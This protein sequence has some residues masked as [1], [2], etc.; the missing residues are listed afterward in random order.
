MKHNDVTDKI[1]KSY[2]FDSSEFNS[3]MK[4]IWQEKVKKGLPVSIDIPND[5]DKEDLKLLSAFRDWL[6]DGQP[7]D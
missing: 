1:E 7:I 3:S 2:N 5:A 4:I 6:D